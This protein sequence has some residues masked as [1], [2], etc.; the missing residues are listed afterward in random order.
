ME[1][2]GTWMADW[3]SR[4]FSPPPTLEAPGILPTPPRS[5]WASNTPLTPE[6]ATQSVVADHQAPSP[7]LHHEGWQPDLLCHRGSPPPETWNSLLAF[8]LIYGEV[9]V[10]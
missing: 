5:S 6:R 1:T 7:P 4:Y 2:Q 9:E 10:V 8:L 3:T